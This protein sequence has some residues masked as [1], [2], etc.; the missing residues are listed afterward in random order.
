MT[1]AEIK[2]EQV[3]VGALVDWPTVAARATG[4]ILF[5]VASAAA[6]PV[7]YGSY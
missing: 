3:R 7:P 6:P 1:V 2:T 4:T 5:S